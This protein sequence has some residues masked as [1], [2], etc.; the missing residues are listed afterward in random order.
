MER[1]EIDAPEIPETE[2]NFS[3]AP[4]NYFMKP[5]KL[6]NSR[7]YEAHYGEDIYSLLLEMYSN[8]TISFKLKKINDLSLY[9]YANRYNYNQ[10]VKLLSMKMKI[11]K[12]W[13]KYLS[14]LI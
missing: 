12:I 7:K 1:Y 9:Q 3:E 2:E 8:D 4:S 5:L 10:L 13:T 11:I 6:I 14:L